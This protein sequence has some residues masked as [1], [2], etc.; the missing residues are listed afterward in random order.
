[1]RKGKTERPSGKTLRW[2]IALLKV[3]GTGG[4]EVDEKKELH[5]K[6]TRDAVEE[7]I[8]LGGA[9]LCFGEFQLWIQ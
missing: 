3:R 1:M 4:I 8:V 7:G 6:V 5:K 9:M 2:C